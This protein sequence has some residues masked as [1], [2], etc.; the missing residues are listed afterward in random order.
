[1]ICDTWLL[2]IFSAA[3]MKID[4]SPL[5][6]SEVGFT[7]HNFHSIGTPYDSLGSVKNFAMA[8]LRILNCDKVYKMF[9]LIII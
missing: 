1:M 4:Q 2:L 6:G 5:A 8:S 3:K 9:T 7:F